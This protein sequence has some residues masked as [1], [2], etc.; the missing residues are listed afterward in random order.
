MQIVDERL[1]GDD[2]KK[3]KPDGP[4]DK[5]DKDAPLQVWLR[6]IVRILYFMK[7]FLHDDNLI[8]VLTWSISWWHNPGRGQD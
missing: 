6:L 8:L 4:D 5:Y 2:D 3:D 7:Y 1:W